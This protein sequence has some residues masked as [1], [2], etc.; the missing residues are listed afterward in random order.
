MTFLCSTFAHPLSF[1]HDHEID[2]VSTRLR[3]RVLI[4]NIDVGVRFQL[5]QIPPRS[6]K[7][8]DVSQ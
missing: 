6:L 7:R 1:S 3:F 5:A 8:L 4:K 2:E